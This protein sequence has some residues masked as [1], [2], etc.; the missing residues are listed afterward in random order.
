MTKNERMAEIA[1]NLLKNKTCNN[2]NNCSK[3]K[4]KSKE[5]YNTCLKWVELLEF[6]FAINSYNVKAATKKLKVNWSI[7]A[8]QDLLS[9][10]NYSAEDELI[11]KV[12]NEIND[13]IEMK[14]EED[15]DSNVIRALSEWVPK[16]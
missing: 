7:F 8:E 1:K 9:G 3:C 15:S 12:S 14:F 4:L 11:N 5:E 13:S 2:C 16:K 6:Q 10:F